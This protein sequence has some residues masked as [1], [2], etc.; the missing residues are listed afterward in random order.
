MKSIVALYFLLSLTQGKFLDLIRNQFNPPG[1]EV[2]APSAIPLPPIEVPMTLETNA[3]IETFESDLITDQDITTLVSSTSESVLTTTLQLSTESTETLET[4]ITTQSDTQDSLVETITDI[5]VISN[6]LKLSDSKT[7][8]VVENLSRQS[9]VDT[10]DDEASSNSSDGYSSS[11]DKS[12]GTGVIIGVSLFCVVLAVGGIFFGLPKYKKWTLEKN[13]MDAPNWEKIRED[14][15]IAEMEQYYD[16][17][18]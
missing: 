5:Q 15:K 13:D 2:S 4:T 11:K 8:F 6:D 10:V 1:I 12:T 16:S 3:S 14:R 18:S 9:P 7:G 17:F